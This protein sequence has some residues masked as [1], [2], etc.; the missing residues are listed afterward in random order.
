[1]S[2]CSAFG[3]VV[4]KY[5]LTEYPKT[6]DK[7]LLNFRVYTMAVECRLLRQWLLEDRDVQE[8]EFL[9]NITPCKCSLENMIDSDCN[10][11]Y[12]HC[13]RLR[14]IV[15]FYGSLYL[16][17]L[18]KLYCKYNLSIFL[19]IFSNVRRSSDMP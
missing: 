6:E 8:L 9:P 12:C 2:Y 16:L 7:V 13:K 10:S 5:S 14:D 11:Y 4:N 17:T 19:S 15:I 1:M 18:K 3:E